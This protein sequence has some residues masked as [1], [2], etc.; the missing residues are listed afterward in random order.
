MAR[1]N[2]LVNLASTNK[3]PVT[4]SEYA[5][6]WLAIQALTNPSIENEK[7]LKSC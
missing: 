7:I 2:G 6:E 1:S 5:D 3:Q 4:E